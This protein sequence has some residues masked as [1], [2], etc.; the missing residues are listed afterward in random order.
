MPTVAIT[1]IVSGGQTGAD[2]GG[3]DAAIEV[4]VARGGWCPRGR[5]PGDGFSPRL[6]PSKI[7]SSFCWPQRNSRQLH[8][9]ELNIG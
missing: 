4:G 2:R 9:L 5:K 1:K 6:G 8:F 3:L 7:T